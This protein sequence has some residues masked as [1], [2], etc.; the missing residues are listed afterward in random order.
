M[1]AVEKLE[2][3]NK[4]RPDPSFWHQNI[5]DAHALCRTE[6]DYQVFQLFLT[7]PADSFDVSRLD[8]PDFQTVGQAIDKMTPEERDRVIIHDY[9]DHMEEIITQNGNQI[10]IDVRHKSTD[11]EKQES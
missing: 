9:P 8:S 6:R 5:I 1:Q 11:D 4:S 10:I 3:L 7:S 2:K